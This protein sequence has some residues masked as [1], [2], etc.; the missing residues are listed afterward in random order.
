[1]M[2][3]PNLHAIQY[4]FNRRSLMILLIIMVGVGALFTWLLVHFLDREA[5]SHL[6]TQASMIAHAID[7]KKIKSL[8]AT[9]RDLNSPAYQSIKQQLRRVRLSH[10]PIRFLYLMGQNKDAEIFFYLDS[11]PSSSPDYVSP[12]FIYTEVSDDYRAVFRTQK[13]A[14]VGPVSDRWGVVMTALVPILDTKD[15]RLIALLGMDVQVSDWYIVILL[16]SLLPIIM[17]LSLMCVFYLWFIL[18]IKNKR[19]K[20][21]MSVDSL[22][23]LYSRRWILEQAQIEFDRCGRTYGTLSA[24]IVDIDDFKQV[25]DNYG[26]QAGDFVLKMVS[27]RIKLSLR[28][29]DF[30]G[31]LGGEEFVIL[32]PD[33]PIENAV[34]VAEKH[35]KAIS[36]LSLHS[37][38][39]RGLNKVTASFGVAST[40]CGPEDLK[41]LLRQADSAL[42]E[43]KHQG[44]NRVSS[45]QVDQPTSSQPEWKRA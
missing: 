23:K 34:Y 15:Q 32:L 29:T 10:E 27:T 1:M 36:E 3:K 16:K 24:I 22:T 14:V 33:T 19:L 45:Y 43:S 7:S 4:R 40:E 44:K 28:K 9:S 20:E 17:M 21:A 26:H 25:N 13:G 38:L 18:T 11:Q 39:C 42:Y 41:E 8:S 35:C 2:G 31:R 30:A 5:K 6:L 12:G 37:S